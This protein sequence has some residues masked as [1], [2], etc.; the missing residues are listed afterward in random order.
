[1]IS[2]RRASHARMHA[3]SRL[4]RIASSAR[5]VVVAAPRTVLHAFCIGCTRPLAT[6]ASS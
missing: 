5:F 3:Y 1:M 6:V 4:R 2:V